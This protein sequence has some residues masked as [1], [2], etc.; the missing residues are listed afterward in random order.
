[1]MYLE[2]TRLNV[3]RI[4]PEIRYA[5]TQHKV[6]YI[7]SVYKDLQHFV[8]FLYFAVTLLPLWLRKFN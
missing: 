1:M 6:N 2:L 7:V 5:I 8:S 4:R 3:Y